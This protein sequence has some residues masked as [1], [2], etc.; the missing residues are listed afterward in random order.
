MSILHQNEKS[1]DDYE[2]IYGI[3]DYYYSDLNESEYEKVLEFV[4][5][6]AERTGLSLNHYLMEFN[7]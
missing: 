6:E 2:I 4:L 7:R 5:T 1:I 3:P